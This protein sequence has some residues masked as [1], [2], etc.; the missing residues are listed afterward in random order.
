MPWGIERKQCHIGVNSRPFRRFGNQLHTMASALILG[1]T[2]QVGQ[3]VL[4]ELLASPHFI[5]VGEYGRRVTD[6]DSIKTGSERL[7]Q[8]KVDFDNIDKAGLKEGK[9]DVVFI[10]L[11]TTKAD[12]GSTEAFE[13]IDREYVLNAARAA[14]VDDASHSQRVVYV[15][16]AGADPSSMFYY[17]RSKGL[18]ELGLA[19]LGYDTIIFR[20]GALKGIKR[21]EVRVKEIFFGA[22]TSILSHVSDSVEIQVPMLAKSIVEAGVVGSSGLPD[23]ARATQSGSD[24]AKFTLIDNAGAIA[25]AKK[26]T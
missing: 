20:P 6:K 19:K 11:G 14:R 18:T 10:T 9:W 24:G 16:S 2:G 22:V 25:M 8:K 1:A 4:K 26:D 15:S 13:K 21:P 3:F 23:V 7:E 5:R 12:A 17:P